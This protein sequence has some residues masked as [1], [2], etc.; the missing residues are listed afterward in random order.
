M[1]G[2]PHV[3][4]HHGTYVQRT[5]DA[6]AESIRVPERLQDF[7]EMLQCHSIRPMGSEILGSWDQ[8]EVANVYH[9]LLAVDI[10][11]HTH[12]HKQTNLYIY[13]CVYSYIYIY[14]YALWIQTATEKV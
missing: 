11:T 3:G 4:A 13:I 6:S 12:K 8:P 14:M 2:N 1:Y 5:Q 9:T 10:H 7:W